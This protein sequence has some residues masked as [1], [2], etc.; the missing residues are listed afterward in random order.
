MEA[1]TASMVAELLEKRAPR[2]MVQFFERAELILYGAVG[3][4]LVAIALIALAAEVEGI[5]NY[6]VTDS[7]IIG[8]NDL[9]AAIIVL[10]LLMTVVGYMKTKSINLGLLLGA[11]LTA[12]VRKIILF[13]YQ[14]GD[15]QSF[16]LALLATAILVVA[17]HFVSD[18]TIYT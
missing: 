9:F 16:E 12:M 14:P 8:L 18:K 3:I 11:A 10:E 13:G 15:V 7:P 2:R 17:I 6:F 4:L 5:T 1:P